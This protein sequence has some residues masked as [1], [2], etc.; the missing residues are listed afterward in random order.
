M[1][2]KISD[3][4][5]TIIYRSIAHSCKPGLMVGKYLESME[6]DARSVIAVRQGEV[7]DHKCVLESGDRIK[8]ISVIAGG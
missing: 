6:I 7:V 8:L 4:E 3:R 5:C 1:S 2:N